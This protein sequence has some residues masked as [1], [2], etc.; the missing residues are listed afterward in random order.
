M[1]SSVGD[2]TVKVW[3]TF[4]GHVK[5]TSRTCEGYVKDI[6][7]TR[8]GYRAY[9]SL[10]PQA[11]FWSLSVFFLL[12]STFIYY[13]FSIVDHTHINFTRPQK[14]LCNLIFVW[15]FAFYSGWSNSGHCM[16][17]RPPGGARPPGCYTMTSRGAVLSWGWG[18]GAARPTPRSRD[19]YGS[20]VICLKRTSS[21]GKCVV[22]MWL[23][24]ISADFSYHNPLPFLLPR[25]KYKSQTSLVQSM[26]AIFRHNTHTVNSSDGSSPFI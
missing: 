9:V 24:S 16:A 20:E 4:E 10:H 1:V 11:S 2:Q 25:Q 18:A 19:I 12:N 21:R 14:G 15:M 8:Q 3:K 13:Y 22:Y 23:A 26:R 5:D 17:T 6:W 7:R